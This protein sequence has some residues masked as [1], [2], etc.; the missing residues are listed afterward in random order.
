MTIDE[1]TVDF[2]KGYLGIDSSYKE[3]DDFLGLC[4]KSSIAYIE[5]YI[6]ADIKSIEGD[7]QDL[8]VACIYLAQFFYISK[9]V[10]TT[11]DYEDKT[12]DSLLNKYR[13]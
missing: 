5:S 10:T 9:I 12:I 2:L 3:D 13:Y 1:V 7:G 8:I 11:V 6:G 4:I